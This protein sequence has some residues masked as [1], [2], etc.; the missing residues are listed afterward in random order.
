MKPSLTVVSFLSPVFRVIGVLLFLLSLIAFIGGTSIIWR[1]LAARWHSA[2]VA[3]ALAAESQKEHT[4][5]TQE[6]V[7][8]ADLSKN[9]ALRP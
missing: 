1:V 6:D 2:V 7:A 5:I 9:V 8:I 3:S 4:K